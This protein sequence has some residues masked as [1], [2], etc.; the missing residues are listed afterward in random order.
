MKFIDEITLTVASGRGGAGCVSFRRESMTPRGGPDGG[1]GGKGGDIIFRVNPHLN[2]LIDLHH[3]KILQA[4]AGE[5]GRRQNQSGKNGNDLIISVPQGTVIKDPKGRVL[6]DL[7]SASEVIF[8]KGGL[9]G[10][11]N[12]FYKSSVHQAP[13]I[14]QKGMPGEEKCITLEL[15]LLA[16]VGIIGFPNAGKSTLISVIS[17]AKPKIADYPFTT[18]VPNLGVVKIGEDKSF[19]A[20]D[21]PGLVVG[22]HL[23]VGL[24][25]QF[26]RH[27]QRTRVFIHLI[28]ISSMNDRD[29]IQD[30]RD[31]NQELKSY[32]HL[33]K[34]KDE[35]QPL[36]ERPQIVVFNKSDS[37][38]EKKLDEWV[39]KIFDE[40][41]VNPIIISAATRKN[42]NSLI[43][44]IE[45]RLF[46]GTNDD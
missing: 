30:Y 6:I 19:V 2:S 36:S 23:G 38:D 27:I 33:Q 40:E 4:E 11:G 3:K 45:K 39:K 24:G 20:A 42:L 25:T 9:G 31:I 16:D 15:K 26:L 46:T 1:D 28:D 34:H 21:I 13:Q 29:P 35:F 32:D 10:K 17:S 5:S 44:A 22:A 37:A 7:G 18:L 12:T 41:G 8:L 43:Y 14:A